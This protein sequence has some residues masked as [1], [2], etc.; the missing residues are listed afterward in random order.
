MV[1]QNGASSFYLQV[2]LTSYIACEHPWTF[3]VNENETAKTFVKKKSTGIHSSYIFNI[4]LFIS[5]QEVYKQTAKV[6]AIFVCFLS[7][8]TH[9]RHTLPY[10]T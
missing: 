6:N 5:T 3:F 9:H 7:E 8:Y 10:I 2:N 4:S 1:Q